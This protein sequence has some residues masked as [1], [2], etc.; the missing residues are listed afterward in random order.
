MAPNVA[1]VYG[2]F[3]MGDCERDVK[4]IHDSFPKIDGLEVA[5]PV[6]GNAFDFNSLKDMKMLIVVTSSTYGMPPTNFKEFAH[7]L[8]LAATSNPGCLS[9]LQHTVYGNGDETY[10]NTYMNMPRYVDKLLEKCG[11][12]RFYARGETGEPHADMGTKSCKCVEWTPA[13]WSAAA[14]AVK[15][16]PSA[17]AVAWDAL[18]AKEGSEHHQK[19]TEWNL[20]KLVKKLGELKGAPSAFSKL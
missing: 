10:F 14:E 12:R 5:A 19:V 11:S 3:F 15:A 2:S 17:P 6:E 18:W 13:M 7:Q 9:H 8:L 16:G 1:L 4:T 20:E